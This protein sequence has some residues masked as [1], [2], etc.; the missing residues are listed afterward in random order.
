LEIGL[1]VG[2]HKLLERSHEK[3]ENPSSSRF[4]PSALETLVRDEVPDELVSAGVDEPLYEGL[5]TNNPGYPGYR[6]D[7]AIWNASLYLKIRY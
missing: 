1:Q 2:A 7:G 4:S 6:S 3:I 5:Q